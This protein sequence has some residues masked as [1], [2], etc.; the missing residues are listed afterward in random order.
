M[1]GELEEKIESVAANFRN[2]TF[3]ILLQ[4][5]FIIPTNE[6]LNAMGV[7]GEELMEVENL[8]MPKSFLNI[9]S[10]FLVYCN[11]NNLM[12]FFFKQLIDAYKFE[13]ENVLLSNQENLRNKFL[14]SWIVYLL[15]SNSFKNEKLKNS[16]FQFHFT[17]KQ[18]L[19]DI[20]S[21][22]PNHFTLLFLK[23]ISKIPSFTSEM[24]PVDFEKIKQLVN[25][26]NMTNQIEISGD[27][28][29][30]EESNEMDMDENQSF[31]DLSI[32]EKPMN[33]MKNKTDFFNTYQSNRNA[34]SSGDWEL[35]DDEN[36]NCE[37]LKLGFVENQSCLNFNLDICQLIESSR[38]DGHLN[39]SVNQSIQE[40]LPLSGID[41]F[42]SS[43]YTKSTER[44]MQQKIMNSYWEFA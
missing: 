18:V 19:L 17:Y 11:E 25:F 28:E 13:V 4:D 40:Y 9:W 21:S 39:G 20:L 38:D 7:V 26:L 31:Y 3:E 24:D 14:L 5:G 12:G 15:R 33:T 43:E 22:N 16:K 32:F 29:V 30:Y 2:E 23:E 35:I 8:S 41:K 37:N 34:R 27:Q 1:S 36:W 42:F 44:S 10:K 6:Q